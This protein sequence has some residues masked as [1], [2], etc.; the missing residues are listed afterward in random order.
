MPPIPPRKSPTTPKPEPSP[1]KPSKG[2]GKGSSVP[3]KRGTVL[4]RLPSPLSALHAIGNEETCVAC[5][6]SGVSSRG[7]RCFPCNGTGK[8][9]V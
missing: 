6:G 3:P 8:K 2:L 4:S 5:G 7:G 9:R 1:E